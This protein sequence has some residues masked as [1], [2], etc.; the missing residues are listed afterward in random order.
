MCTTLKNTA[1][2]D[3]NKHFVE[4]FSDVYCQ[5]HTS[6][7]NPLSVVYHPNGTHLTSCCSLHKLSA[8]HSV[9]NSFYF[10]NSLSHTIQQSGLELQQN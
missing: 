4:Q 9:F 2:S 7:F 5:R 8:L 3:I 10:Y 6:I 1:I